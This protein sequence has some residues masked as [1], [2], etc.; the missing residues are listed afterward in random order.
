MENIVVVLGIVG[1]DGRITL[2]INDKTYK[3]N[4][5]GKAEIDVNELVISG[6]K[7][8]FEYDRLLGN[9]IGDSQRMELYELFVGSNRFGLT[10]VMSMLAIEKGLARDTL[11]L[12][13]KNRVLKRVD[14][15]WKLEIDKKEAIKQVMR[16]YKKVVEPE[17][18]LEPYKFTQ[19][20]QTEGQMGIGPTPL[21]VEKNK[22][23]VK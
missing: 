7:G 10:D 17:E 21:I 19:M 6:E 14:T 11:I 1:K 15:Q 4:E 8:V 22:R 9:M 20:A 16:S 5:Q 23:S 12:G 3:L 2:S 18:T 13:F